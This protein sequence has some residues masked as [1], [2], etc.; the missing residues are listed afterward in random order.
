MI[1]IRFQKQDTPTEVKVSCQIFCF[2]QPASPGITSES[3][4]GI[5]LFVGSK[6]N[7]IWPNQLKNRAFPDRSFSGGI[8]VK[9]CQMKFSLWKSVEECV[10]FPTLQG[11]PRKHH[12]ARWTTDCLKRT[13]SCLQIILQGLKACGVS[14]KQDTPTEVRASCWIFSSYANQLLRQAVR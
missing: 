2:V 7:I 9:G 11:A 14:V 3:L 1:N 6:R 13:G 5:S 12:I 4:T 10:R 8:C